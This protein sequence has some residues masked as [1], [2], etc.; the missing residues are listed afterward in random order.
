M[1]YTKVILHIE[2]LIKEGTLSSGSRLPSIRLLATE[3]NCSKSTVQKAYEVLADNR[4]AYVIDKSGYFLMQQ[5]EKILLSDQIDFA[6]L[7][8]KNELL[9]KKELQYVFN[10]V[11]VEDKYDTVEQDVEGLFSLRLALKHYFKERKIFTTV[12][13]LFVLPTLE[14]TYRMI[15]DLLLKDGGGLL[16]E[17]PTDLVLVNSVHSNKVFTFNRDGHSIDFNLLE[18]HLIKNS[19][20]A[21]VVTPDGHIPTGAKMSLEDKERLLSLCY[22]YNVYIIELNFIEDGYSY[23]ETQSLYALDKEDIVFHIKTFN[24]IISNYFDLATVIVPHKFAMLTKKYKEKYIGTTPILSQLVINHFLEN[25]FDSLRERFIAI[26]EKK[27]KIMDKLIKGIEF[28]NEFEIFHSKDRLYTFIKVP[29]DFNLESLLLALKHRNV[30]IHNINPFF[31]G[32]HTFKG[33]VISTMNVDETQ[34]VNGINIFKYYI[35]NY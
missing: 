18:F 35:E 20:K 17:N 14:I 34:I 29:F 13:D 21:L 10:Q 3:L 2:N 4:I 7:E 22:E 6:S 9:D 27:F 15:N 16:V 25:N 30:L 23:K 12:H 28:P 26:K 8:S 31:V 11:M 19:I 5:P 24:H 1:K 32:E 33:L